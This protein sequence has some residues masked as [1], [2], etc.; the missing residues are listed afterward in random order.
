MGVGMEILLERLLME[1][2]LVVAQM[3]LW[4]LFKWLRSKVAVL[5]PAAA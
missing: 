3:A 5:T 4:Q 1:I 2:L